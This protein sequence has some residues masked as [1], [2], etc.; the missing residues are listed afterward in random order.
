LG[1]ENQLGNTIFSKSPEDEAYPEENLENDKCL[2]DTIILGSPK[3]KIHVEKELEGEA[4]SGDTT[5]V[6]TL[7]DADIMPPKHEPKENLATPSLVGNPRIK[8]SYKDRL[9]KVLK[10]FRN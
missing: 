5:L 3:R 10:K 2:G 7:P 1:D 8:K 4:P 9:R 6:E